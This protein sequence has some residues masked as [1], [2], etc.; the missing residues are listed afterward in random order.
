[1]RNTNSRRASDVARLPET[2]RRYIRAP[3]SRRNSIKPRFSRSNHT[4]RK[5]MKGG[6]IV[7]HHTAT[8]SGLPLFFIFV[9]RVGGPLLAK[10]LFCSSP[11]GTLFAFLFFPS[12]S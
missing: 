1:M 10:F 9:G 8:P 2:A 3:A 12:T 5:K 7:S 6:C 11:S 4:G